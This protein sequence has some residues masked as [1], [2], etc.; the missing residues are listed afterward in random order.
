MKRNIDVDT[1]KSLIKHKLLHCMPRTGDYPTG[2][3]GFGMFRRDTANQSEHCFYR[4]LISVVVQGSKRSLMGNQEYN[5]GEGQS[6]VAAVDIPSLNYVMTASSNKPFLSL[7]SS[8][9][10]SRQ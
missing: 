3:E 4:P 10:F 8:C 9:F 2:I 6:L 7:F 1:A 5:Y